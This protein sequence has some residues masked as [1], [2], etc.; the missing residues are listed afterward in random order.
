MYTVMLRVTTLNT[1]QRN[2]LKNTI[3]KSRWNLKI[4]QVTLKKRKDEK[5]NKK[6]NTRNGRLRHPDF[7]DTLN[8]NGLNT[9]QKS[10][11]GNMDKNK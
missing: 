9:N 6:T 10:R 3:N 8:V 4:C 5:T 2:T 11:I 7:N 1:I